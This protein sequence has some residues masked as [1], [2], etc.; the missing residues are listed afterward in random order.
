MNE[1]EIISLL[2]AYKAGKIKEEEIIEK[3]L[4]LPFEDIEFAKIDHHRQLRKGISEAILALKK[5]PEQVLKI[6]ER[7]EKEDKNILVTKATGEHFKLIKEKYGAA[8][9]YENSGCIILKRD[10]EIYGKG[11]VLVLAAGTSDYPVA[12]EAYVSLDVLGNRAELIIDVGVAGL[13]RLFNYRDK[14]NE[15]RVIIAVAGM[16]AVLPS[17]VAG[18]SKAPVIGVP[19]S[20]GYGSHFQGLSSLL[21][22]LN[23]CAP[24]IAIVNIDN[25][26]GAACLASIIN[27]L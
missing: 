13:H 21:T 11:L 7:M 9:F 4:K 3:L 1:R 15:A 16:D 12:E 24:G 26:Y 18:I 23:S 8:K 27:R 14:I 25:G 20:V 2:Q 5:T 10:E 22:M 6:W 19:T 17:I